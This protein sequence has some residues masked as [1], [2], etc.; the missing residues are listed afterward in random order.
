MAARATRIETQVGRSLT[1]GENE[2][3]PWSL[4]GVE[5]DR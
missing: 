5:A 3:L 1:P 2:I 4:R